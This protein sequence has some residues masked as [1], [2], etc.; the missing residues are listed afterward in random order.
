M[1]ALILAALAL[2]IWLYLLLGRG[3][4]WLSSQRDDAVMPAPA[5]WPKLTVV[6]PARV[7]HPKDKAYVSYCTSSR[8]CNGEH[9]L[10]GP[11]PSVALENRALVQRFVETAPSIVVPVFLQSALSCPEIDGRGRDTVPHAHLFRRE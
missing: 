3:G 8:L 11:T 7:A 5:V 4:F 9:W 2:A 10:R 6:I 1:L